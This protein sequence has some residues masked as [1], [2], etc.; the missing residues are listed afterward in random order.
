MI[1]CVVGQILNSVPESSITCVLSFKQALQYLK[2]ALHAWFPF[3]MIVCVG[4]VPFV[5]ETLKSCET[6]N[7]GVFNWCSQ[8]GPTKKT[9]H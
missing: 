7:T 5:Q 8:S 1:V 6:T 2:A 4:V 9:L 3:P